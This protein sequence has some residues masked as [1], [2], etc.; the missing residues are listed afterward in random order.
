MTKP[1]EAPKTTGIDLDYDDLWVFWVEHYDLSPSSAKW[2]AL[3]QFTGGNAF[4]MVDFSDV[5]KY[6][7]RPTC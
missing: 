7:P 2:L 4:G 3:Y 5:Y 6:A 1:N